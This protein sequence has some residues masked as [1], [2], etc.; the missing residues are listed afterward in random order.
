[1]SH[2]TLAVVAL[3]LCLAALV[4]L[5]Y[6]SHREDSMSPQFVSLLQAVDRIEAKQ[7]ADSKAI[8]D[9]QAQVTQLQ[10]QLATS[11]EDAAALQQ[12]LDRLNA[13]APAAQ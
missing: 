13:I 11:Q 1:M 3:S 7:A 10:G 5:G 8:T 4:A 2:H 6:L 9:L 12:T